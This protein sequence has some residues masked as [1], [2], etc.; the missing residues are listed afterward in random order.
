M[1][2]TAQRW[3]VRPTH[4]H[5]ATHWHPR[6]IRQHLPRG[7]GWRVARAEHV[8][9]L[10]AH[11][12]LALPLPQP[13]AMQENLRFSR[14][15]SLILVSEIHIFFHL[16]SSPKVDFGVQT[17]SPLGAPRGGSVETH[18][19]RHSQPVP[20]SHTHW[21]CRSALYPDLGLAI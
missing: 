6:R 8:R 9:E 3:L 12:L 4:G 21:P 11:P 19:R 2:G 7:C 16:P 1:E 10:Q 13:Q 5:A 15:S 20:Q 18:Y 14:I 17:R